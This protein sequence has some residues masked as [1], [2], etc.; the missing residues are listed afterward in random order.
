MAIV[1]KPPKTKRVGVSYKPGT[2][3]SKQPSPK[4]GMANPSS[5][6][7]GSKGGKKC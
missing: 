3:Y 5:S 4:G 6:K 1:S 2:G 7:G